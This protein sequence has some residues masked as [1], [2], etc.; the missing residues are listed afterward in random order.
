MIVKAIE[1]GDASEVEKILSDKKALSALNFQIV[2][3]ETKNRDTILTLAAYKGNL[4]ILRKL[5]EVKP[6][7][8]NQVK[9]GGV[10]PLFVAVKAEHENIVKELLARGARP[11]LAKTDGRT[12]LYIAANEGKNVEIFDLLVKSGHVKLKQEIQAALALKN[13]YFAQ[14]LREIQK[15]NC[16][17]RILKAEKGI[18]ISVQNV[19]NMGETELKERMQQCYNMVLAKKALAKLDPSQNE[20]CSVCMECLFEKDKVLASPPCG[21]LHCSEC[22]TKL[23]TVLSRNGQGKVI[24][25][26]VCPLCRGEICDKTVLEVTQN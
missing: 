2:N 14:T 17:K 12:P 25:E 26:A 11:D 5:L 9:E 23:L 19:E 21:H 10:T 7:Y 1:A 15:Q 20:D 18:S 4:T 6:Y 24:G 13:Y 8:I 22:F 16:E 3:P